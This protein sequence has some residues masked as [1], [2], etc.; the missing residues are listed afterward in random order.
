M[1]WLAFYSSKNTRE[2]LR[3]NGNGYRMGLTLV[4]DAKLRDFSV[5]NGKFDGFKV[6]EINT[7]SS[8]SLVIQIYL[9]QHAFLCIYS[10]VGAFTGRIS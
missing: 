8:Y 7:F 10:G 2:P 6:M 5:I 1:S 3:V 9:I 4:I